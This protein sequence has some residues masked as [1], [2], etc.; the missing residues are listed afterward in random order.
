MLDVTSFA[1]LSSPTIVANESFQSLSFVGA[2]WHLEAA[3]AALAEI[4]DASVTRH[5][6]SA[7]SV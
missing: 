6:L 1:R 2:R 3:R 5:F 4:V 7:I